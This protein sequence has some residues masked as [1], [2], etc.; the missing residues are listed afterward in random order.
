MKNIILYGQPVSSP[1]SEILNL[2]VLWWSFGQTEVHLPEIQHTRQVSEMSE[3]SAYHVEKP[4]V[5][6]KLFNSH[7]QSEWM[8]H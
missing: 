7:Q 5:I 6:A 4:W 2:F 1:C 8:L 3:G